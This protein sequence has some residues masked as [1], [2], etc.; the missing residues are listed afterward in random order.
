MARP[1]VGAAKD[2][3]LVVRLPAEVRARLERVRE[4]LSKRAGGVDLVTSHVVREAIARGLD[5]IERDLGRK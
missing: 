1:V 4:A 2:R 3:Q 5:S